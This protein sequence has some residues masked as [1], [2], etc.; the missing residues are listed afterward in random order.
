MGTQASPYPSP[1]KSKR[2]AFAERELFRV[3]MKGA[4]TNRNIKIQKEK[5]ERVPFLLWNGRIHLKGHGFLH[6]IEKRDRLGE[7]HR[8]L[9]HYKW[10]KTSS[11]ISVVGKA[12]PSTPSFSS[13]APQASA[14][15]PKHASFRETLASPTPPTTFT[16]MRVTFS[17]I[18]PP[19]C[20]S[21]TAP[22]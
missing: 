21:T 5:P 9:T 7:N 14:K 4:S 10:T 20:E 8:S 11:V 13:V 18:S 2:K 1:L 19:F 16:E 22:S 15:P 6:K 12:P 17:T 3:P